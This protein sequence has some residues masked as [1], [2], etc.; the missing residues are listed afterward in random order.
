MGA[1]DDEE[2]KPLKAHR[3]VLGFWFLYAGSSRSWGVHLTSSEAFI[4]NGLTAL[5]CFVWFGFGFSES[6]LCGS[7]VGVCLGIWLA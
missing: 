3:K 6:W 7:L 1:G 4:R 5:L 2:N